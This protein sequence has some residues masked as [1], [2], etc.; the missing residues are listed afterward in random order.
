[1]GTEEM[2]VLYMAS[3]AKQ[4]MDI[5]LTT[6]FARYAGMNMRHPTRLPPPRQL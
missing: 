1:M 5:C 2:Q 3:Y 4:S 6:P